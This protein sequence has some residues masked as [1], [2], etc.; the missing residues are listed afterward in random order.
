MNDWAK[1]NWKLIAAFAAGVL[2]GAISVRQGYEGFRFAGSEYILIKK[3]SIPKSLSIQGRWLYETKASGADLNYDQFACK[4]ILG[5]AD[6]SQGQEGAPVSNEFSIDNA[7]R[8]ACVDSQGKVL[9]TNVSWNS[10]NASVLPNS[11]KI[12]VSLITTDPNPRL[13]YIEGSIPST[14]PEKTPSEFSGNMYY[15]NTQNQTYGSTI[16]RFCKEGTECART[17]EKQF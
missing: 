5:V 15:L 8:K 12:I 14:E 10:R 17:I 11:R 7:I 3:A 9:K 2:L 16:I 13:G 6:I 4:S 1:Q